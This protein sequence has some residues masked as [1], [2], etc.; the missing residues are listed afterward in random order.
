MRYQLIV[1]DV[2]GTLVDA[3][4]HIPAL[5][6]RAITKFERTGGRFTLATGRMPQSAQ[7]FVDE[8]R[9]RT[10]YIVYNGSRIVDPSGQALY[11]RTLEKAA[12]AAALEIAGHREFTAFLYQEDRILVE[13]I[14]A[15]VKRQERK[16]GVACVAVGSLEA[17]LSFA[18]TKI[19]FVGHIEEVP[20]LLQ[21]LTETLGSRAAVARSEPDYVEVLPPGVDKAAALR[22]LCNTLAIELEQVMAIGD[23]LND[24]EMLRLA[25]TGVAPANADPEVRAAADVVTSADN[26]HGAVAEAIT[27]ALSSRA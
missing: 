21:A 16:D 15:R 5:N 27:V 23:N 26:A 6:K 18:P 19:L 14:D 1:S 8:L 20:V 4:Q 9:I 12:A 11:N 17:Q 13:R 25:G 10:P 22:A 2:D 7:P 3:D 24:L